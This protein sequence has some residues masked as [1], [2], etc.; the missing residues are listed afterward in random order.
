MV[1]GVP[2]NI[3]ELKKKANNQQSWRERL[4]AVNELKNYDCQQSRD[5]LTR[6]ALHDIVFCVKEAAFRATQAMGV[7]KN[8]KPIYLSKKPKGNLVKEITKKLSR[9][10]DSLPNGYSLDDF[11]EAFKHMYPIAYDIYDGDKGNRFDQWL[12]NCIRAFPSKS[13][14]SS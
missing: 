9:V 7:T 10:H 12:S 11:K 4:S 6:L 2:P 14:S 1:N 5:I 13:N 3:E 8:G